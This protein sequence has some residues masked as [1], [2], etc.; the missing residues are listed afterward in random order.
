MP[1]KIK[2]ISLS[3]PDE[4]IQKEIALLKIMKIKMLRDSDWTQLPD[5]PINEK[6]LL[7]WRMWR[8]LV[9]EMKITFNNIKDVKQQLEELEKN[10][11]NGY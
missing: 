6:N 4:Y 9:R 7:E 10:K 8:S 11:P 5:V 3:K 2:I 1:Q